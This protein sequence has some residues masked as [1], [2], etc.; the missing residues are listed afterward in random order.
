MIFVDF[1]PYIHRESD[2]LSTGKISGIVVGLSAF[3]SLLVLILLFL[4]QRKKL[5]RSAGNLDNK[6]LIKFTFDTYIHVID[7]SNFSLLNDFMYIQS[8][9][10]ELE[11]MTGYFNLGKIKSA[12]Q[13]FASENKIGEGGFGPVYKVKFIH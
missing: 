10:K 8:E 13:N 9:F 11:K 4:W 7:Q 6:L 12:T 3:F 2:N 1:E 5:E